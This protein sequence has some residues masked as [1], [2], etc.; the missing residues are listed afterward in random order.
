MG[1]RITL[2]DPN[3]NYYPSMGRSVRQQILDWFPGQPLSK[4]GQVLSSPGTI[5][6]YPFGNTLRKQM[7][8]ELNVVMQEGVAAYKK[9]Q[10]ANVAANKPVEP[11]NIVPGFPSTQVPESL[12][13][14][15]ETFGDYQQ[16]QYEA[17]VNEAVKAASMA[18]GPDKARIRAS[19]GA[20]AIHWVGKK[21][22]Q[23]G[24][25]QG[26]LVTGPAGVTSKAAAEKSKLGGRYA[27]QTKGAEVSRGIAAQARAAM[28]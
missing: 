18:S 11:V 10:A 25:R 8:A 6:D 17:Q 2:Y 27:P 3:L 28:G 23:Y 21:W 26:M 19:L 15:S 20:K 24:R 5:I 12:E 22:W 16:E 4:I 7:A 9:E 14:R 1:V 13:Y